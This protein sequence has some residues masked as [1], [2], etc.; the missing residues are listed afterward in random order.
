MVF[1]ENIHFM[2]IIRRRSMNQL[3]SCPV[4]LEANLTTV[5]LRLQLQLDADLTGAGAALF[6]EE[7]GHGFDK[8]D[9]PDHGGGIGASLRVTGELLNA[10][11]ELHSDS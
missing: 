5:S 1:F 8:V 11:H 9:S 3:M 6:M 10:L 2:L 4:V 7:Q